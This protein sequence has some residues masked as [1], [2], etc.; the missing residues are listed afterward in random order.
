[1]NFLN[2]EIPIVPISLEKVTAFFYFIY[3]MNISN[4]YSFGKF[5]EGRTHN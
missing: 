1:M 3:C 2:K 5:W 4:L